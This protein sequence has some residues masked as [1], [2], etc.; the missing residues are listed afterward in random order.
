[1]VH[2]EDRQRAQE[3]GPEPI[4]TQKQAERG[5]IPGGLFPP[6][7]KPQQ[8]HFKLVSE[9]VLARAS[10]KLRQLLGFDSMPLTNV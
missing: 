9:E 7:L 1:M 4:V 3:A 6:L 8:D 10:P 5:R 2:K